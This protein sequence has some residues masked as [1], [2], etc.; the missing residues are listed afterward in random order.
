MRQRS[1][2][3]L[4][5]HPT[6]PIQA[7]TRDLGI[8]NAALQQVLA[9]MSKIRGQRQKLQH[10]TREEINVFILST[11]KPRV[12]NAQDYNYQLVLLEENYKRGL[13]SVKEQLVHYKHNESLLN[14]KIVVLKRYL[15]YK[16]SKI[17]V[18]KS[19]LDEISKEKNDR[20]VKIEKFENA[21]QSL[22]KLIGSQITDNSKR[23][24]GY[25][26]YNVVPPPHTGRF[27]PSRI[28]LSHTGLPEFA[29]LSVQSYGNKPIEVVTHTSCV[30]IFEPVK[31]NNGSPIVED[32]ESNEEDEVKSP[33]EKEKTTVKP[34]VDK[35][36]VE[37]PKQ[38]DK[39]ARRLVKYVEMYRTQRP[40]GNHRNWNKLKSHQIAEKDGKWD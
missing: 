10:A 15:S 36:E 6:A 39:P 14:E 4:I 29:E 18:L 8:A 2:I 40:K 20:D 5:V 9:L 25:V 33:P 7:M 17:T 30:K 12:S 21:S 38:N 23:G 24:L 26:S 35:V 22:D 34:S 27:S 32:W 1:D 19:K 37:I 31:K 11:D 16:D 28:D 3:A 13:A